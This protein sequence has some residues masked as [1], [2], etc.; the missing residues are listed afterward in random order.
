LAIEAVVPGVQA[1][2]LVPVALERR[3]LKALYRPGGKVSEIIRGP[4][5]LFLARDV[6]AVELLHAAG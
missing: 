6:H 3:Q 5:S 1:Q 4:A 2:D